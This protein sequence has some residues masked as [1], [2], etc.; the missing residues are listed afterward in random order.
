M[1]LWSVERIH[2]SR[3]V[4]RPLESKKLP[5]AGTVLGQSPGHGL[6]PHPHGSVAPGAPGPA[7]RDHQ[8]Q[9]E[10]RREGHD[11]RAGDP[12]HVED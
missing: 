1:R 7:G 8:P 11:Q 10:Q 9:D 4:R 6:A 12:E 3:P 5:A 2:D